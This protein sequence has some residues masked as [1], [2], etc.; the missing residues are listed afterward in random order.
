M[1]LMVRLITNLQLTTTPLP[2]PPSPS[3]E[4]S[5]QKPDLRAA[6]N[7][8]QINN[9]REE[10]RRKWSRLDVGSERRTFGK[11]MNQSVRDQVRNQN[12][13]ANQKSR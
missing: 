10:S 12:S 8:A 11:I 2:L 4:Q 1:V 13:Q 3:P 9:S 7:F 6:A 5:A